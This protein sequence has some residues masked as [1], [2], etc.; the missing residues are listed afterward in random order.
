MPTWMGSGDVGPR[1]LLAHPRRAGLGGVD[2]VK[3]GGVLLVVAAVCFLL[4][5]WFERHESGWIQLIAAI[6][7][8]IAAATVFAGKKKAGG[9]R[10]PE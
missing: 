6:C 7:L 3:V 1:G 5:A 10:S 8:L 4:A 2:T 9:S